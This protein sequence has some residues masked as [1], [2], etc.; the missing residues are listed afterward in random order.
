MGR[1]IKKHPGGPPYQTDFEL[2]VSGRWLHGGRAILRVGSTEHQFRVSRQNFAVLAPLMA[3][4]RHDQTLVKPWV[5]RGF[6]MGDEIVTHARLL[7]AVT[8]IRSRLPK[9]FRNLREKFARAFQ[10][11]KKGLRWAK[12]AIEFQDGFGYRLSTDP[13]KL[14]LNIIN[15]LLM[16]GSD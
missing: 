11:S 3:R 8:L 4:A 13:A 9:A 16:T 10:D 14:H 12:M 1:R 15:D 7:G 6:L 2:W 5:A